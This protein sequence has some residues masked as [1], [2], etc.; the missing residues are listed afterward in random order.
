MIMPQTKDHQVTRYKL[1]AANETIKNVRTKKVGSPNYF[2]FGNQKSGTSVIGAALAKAMDLDFQ[3]D[4]P[5]ERFSPTYKK[6]SV[7]D[8]N[9]LDTLINR[10]RFRFNEGVFKEPSL[11]FFWK[12]ILQKFPNSKALFVVRNPFENIRSI[13]D[14]VNLIEDGKAV[15]TDNFQAPYPWNHI[16]NLEDYPAIDLTSPRL[17]TIS[18][19]TK[20]AQRWDKA[21]RAANEASHLGHKVITYEAFLEEPQVIMWQLEA[22]NDFQVVLNKAHQKPGAHR[23]LKAE[24]ILAEYKDLILDQCSSTASIFNYI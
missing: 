24:D 20:L 22:T 11:T 6:T 12:E 19:I 13:L 3:N 18:V 5:M 21:A 16:I 15:Q 8:P 4:L 9:Y 10:S 17:S 14:R 23:H 1:Q 7:T 2:V